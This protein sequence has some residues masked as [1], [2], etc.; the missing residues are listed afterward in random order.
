MDRFTW[1]VVAGALVLVAVA[2]GSVALVQGQTAPP[3]LSR[4]E[5]VV[6]AYVEAI[7]TNRPERAWELLAAS[8][9]SGTTRDEFIQ[10][11]TSSGRL[12]E[13]RVAIE[14]VEVT[15]DTAVVRLSRTYGNGGLFGPS[16][17][18]NQTTVRL[19]REAGQWRIT[20]PPDPYLI[21][22][23]RAAGPVASATPT[24][25]PSPTPAPSAT[26]RAT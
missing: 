7:D 22:V 6:R 17:Y 3:D 2:I 23:P 24:P 8:A 25:R 20:V 12:R 10:R 1:G 21:D 4:P 9:R 11:A 26:P 16:S 13:G 5:G 14:S 19:E 18:T 15:G